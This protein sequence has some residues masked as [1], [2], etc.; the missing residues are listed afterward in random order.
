MGFFS[1][2]I[3]PSRRTWGLVVLALWLITTG[4]QRFVNIPVGSLDKILAGMAIVAGLLILL[5]R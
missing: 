3:L 5:D 2:L 4:A 1:R